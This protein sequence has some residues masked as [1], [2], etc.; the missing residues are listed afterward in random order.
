MVQK[1][2]IITGAGIGIGRGT[3]LAFARKGLNVIVTDILEA[4]GRNV[5]KEIESAGGRGRFYKLDVTDTE[6]VNRVVE[7][8]ESVDGGIDVVIANSGIA[9]K[10]PLE[11][12]TDNKWD[13]TLDVDLKGV[14]RIVRAAA[15]G[16]KARRSGA[17]VALS[18]ISGTT[19]GWDEHAH[20]SAAKAGVIGLVRG[21]AIE[22]A[23]S[24]IR[25]N[26]VAPGVIRTAQALSVEHSLGPE[27]LEA[28]ASSI[29]LGRVGEPAD[30][31][32]V[33]AFLASDEARYITGQ[34]IVVDGGF[35]IQQY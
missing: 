24:G 8:V 19:Y 35:T 31:A 5:V 17:I 14:L 3:A 9:H 34:V 25:V 32:D 28:M 4:E 26:G 2:V 11:D 12:M 30:V 18:S 22:L 16:M 20:Y 6:E 15:P 33:I 1:T 29:P 7:D 13:R 10:V 23:R 21:L 27:K